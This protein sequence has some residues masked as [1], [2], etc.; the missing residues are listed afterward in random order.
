MRSRALAKAPA[1][2]EIGYGIQ[3][4]PNAYRMLDWLGVMK[5][6]EPQAVFTK[7][8]ILIDA[9][10][11]RELTRISCGEPF[12]R[13]FRAPYT[14]VH[15]R[16][17]HGALLQAC[18]KREEI[19]L[20]TSKDL[21]SF[22]DRGKTVVAKFADRSEDEGGA[23]RGA[24]GLRSRVGEGRRQA[25]GDRAAHRQGSRELRRPG[26][27]RGREVGGRLGVRGVGFDRRGRSA[28]ARARYPDRRRPA[29][30][31]GARQLPRRRSGRPSEGPV[32][33][34]RHGDL[35]RAGSAPGAIPAAGRHRHE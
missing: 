13:Q 21:V 7:N 25:R 31:G 18:R 14:V 6:L 12:R 35:D 23:L 30:A 17:L 10:T 1:V 15:R 11:D 22:A 34:R 29:A 33:L 5:D 3:Q 28:L 27:N 2:G 8:L 19:A 20:H 16:D 26:K 32:A 24:D 9:L 4:G